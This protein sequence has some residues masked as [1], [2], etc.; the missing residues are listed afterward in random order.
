MLITVMINFACDILDFTYSIYT[1][2]YI[3][4][5]MDSLLTLQL[6]Y[7]YVY[8]VI[9]EWSGY[10]YIY[11]L[12]S[13]PRYVFPDHPIMYSDDS[14]KTVLFNQVKLVLEESN[15]YT[16]EILTGVQLIAMAN[17]E[18][19]IAFNILQHFYPTLDILYLSYVKLDSTE[20]EFAN[21][22]KVIDIKTQIDLH[23]DKKCKFGRIEI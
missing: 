2:S 9:C 20:D 15:K 22:T 8:A 18:G 16:I 19:Y 10:W 3:I 7:Y 21:I 1:S 12:L 23:S 6:I 17:E 14:D 11:L 4:L 13:L 5:I